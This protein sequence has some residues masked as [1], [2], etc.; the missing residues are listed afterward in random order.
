MNTEDQEHNLRREDGNR[1]A[2]HGDRD[3]PGSPVLVIKVERE[4]RVGDHPLNIHSDQTIPFDERI[5]FRFKRVSSLSIVQ[6]IDF[7][8][9]VRYEDFT[10]KR[11]R[12]P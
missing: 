10:G 7:P 1:C 4:V 9:T 2:R 5:V 12:F 6:V 3:K 11:G 8:I